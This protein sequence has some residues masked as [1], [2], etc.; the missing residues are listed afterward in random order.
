MAK[1][2]KFVKRERTISGSV[3]AQE[4]IFSKFDGKSMSLENLAEAITARSLKEIS[5]QAVDMRFTE[6]AVGFFKLLIA[7]AL[8]ELYSG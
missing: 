8:Q 2:A 1:E 5:K 7:A 4:L 3:F 6:E